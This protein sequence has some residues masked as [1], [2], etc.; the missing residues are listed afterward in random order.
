MSEQG[1]QFAW[2]P[3]A[4]E[5][6]DAAEFFAR[7]MSADPAYISHGEIQAGLSPDGLS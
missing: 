3:S 6:C 5:W 2:A 7:V 1:R 4:T